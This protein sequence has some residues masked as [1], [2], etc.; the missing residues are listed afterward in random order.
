VTPSSEVSVDII[1][2]FPLITVVNVLSPRFIRAYADDDAR[3]L[4]IARSTVAPNEI[5]V[6]KND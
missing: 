4:R 5:L 6:R 2:F 3:D 1:Y